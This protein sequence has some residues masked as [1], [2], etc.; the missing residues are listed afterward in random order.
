[1]TEALEIEDLRG[2][3]RMK[4][5]GRLAEI[6][7]NKAKY[8]ADL[9]V[10]AADCLKIRP[11]KG[12][13]MLL[14]LNAV[15]RRVHAEIEDQKR[16]TGM[17]RKVIVKARQPGV[18]LAPSMRVLTAGHRWVPLKEVSVGDELVATDE[19][20]PGGK[21][22]DRKLRTC[23]IEV[24]ASVRKAAFKLV[25]ENGVELIAT[26][27][28]R[29]LTRQRGGDYCQWREV[30]DT[31]AGDFIKYVTAPWG[32]QGLEDAW[33]GGLLDGEGT[34]RARSGAGVEAVV[35]QVAGPVLDRA[36]Q[37]LISRSYTFR[38][39][40]DSR[41]GGETSKLGNKPVHAL[42]LTRSSEIFR[43]VGQ[44]QPVRFRDL[45]WWE[46]KS[47]PGKKIGNGWLAVVSVEPLG[48]REMIDL[49]TSTQTFVCEGVVSH[50]ST[51]VSARYYHRVSRNRGLRAF[52]LTHEQ[53]ATDNVFDMVARFHKNNPQAPHTGAASAKELSFDALDSGFQVG[54]AGSKGTGRS[55]TFQLFHGSEVGLWPHAAEHA[56]GALQAVP[57]APGSEVILEGTANGLGGFFY[58]TAMAAQ[59]KTGEFELIFI[60]WFEH[61]EYAVEPPGDWVPSPELAEYARTKGLDECQTYW[62]YLKNIELATAD[63][64]PTDDLCWRF[65]QEYPSTV[66]EAFRASRQGAFIGGDLVARA[67]AFRAPGQD[68]APLVFG[69][70]VATGGGGEGGDD[71]VIMDRQGR[72]AGRKVYDRFVDKDAVSVAARLA[73]HIDK[74][75]PAMVFID[76]GGGGAQVH[77]I[78]K[79]RGYRNLTLVDFGGRAEDP[80]KYLNKRAEIWGRVRDWLRD[81]GGADIPDDDIL[82]GE[83]TG[84]KGKEDF[85]RRLALEKKADVRKEIGRS[86]DG[87]D[88]LATTF[89]ETVHIA[90]TRR[91]D[92]TAH[93]PWPGGEQ[94]W[95]GA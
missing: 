58:N 94:S 70:D 91:L 1:M 6:D 83:L 56:A 24:V 68:H 13:D 2:A 55:F 85:H 12:A 41:K 29:F 71:N 95:M 43:L 61:G 64:E 15:Q 35:H 51:Y 59:R 19:D 16:R 9:R 8:D 39:Y 50:N 63:G 5:R 34:V 76:T 26:A 80:R 23:R 81:A 65:R 14:R 7:A 38:E 62:A 93:R 3:A 57:K 40:V 90:E 47:L 18:C 72:A 67:R 42:S 53:D 66:D 33:F 92:P 87:A 30:G 20:I 27:E 31:R 60:P 79:D 37:Y 10:F 11:K 88:A 78:L 4:A 69:V 86:P 75:H 89:A 77:D 54:T 82:D 73:R 32:K 45:R 21:G 74:H 44:T 84:P 17:V 25:L 22:R 49:Q 46:G 28:H 48:V 36:R 52:I